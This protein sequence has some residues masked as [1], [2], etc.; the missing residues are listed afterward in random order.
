MARLIRAV[1]RSVSS[2]SYEAGFR[3][4]RCVFGA[5]K[6]QQ[7]QQQRDVCCSESWIPGFRRYGSEAVSLP[8][9]AK[10][11]RI[12]Q[13]EIEYQLEPVPP[14]QPVTRFG[15]FEMIDMP[16]NQLIKLK[17][18]FGG[19]EDIEI[20]V[21]MFDGC[22]FVPTPGDDSTG[23]NR[24]MHLSML[25]HIKKGQGFNQL[26]IICSAW[27]DCLEIQKVAIFP[28][29]QSQRTPYMGPDFKSL[30]EKIQIPFYEFLEERGISDELASFL[31]EYMKNKDRIEV[32][33]WFQKVQSLV[34]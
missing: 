30:D 7:Q 31:H 14:S 16:G 3:S 28:L 32:V 15:N 12:I 27:P 9:E 4:L 26:K 6:Q 20:E 23:T 34:E 18:K 10:M 25:L 17:G 13:K 21:G 33:R 5:R 22:I 19:S 11:R 8:F 24:H 1:Q 2:A 29:D